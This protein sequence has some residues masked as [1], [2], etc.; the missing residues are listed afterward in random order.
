MANATG[1]YDLFLLKSGCFRAISRLVR[2]RRTGSVSVEFALVIPVLMLMVVGIADVGLVLAQYL[3]VSGALSA[4]GQY[5]LI[6]PDDTA[7]VEQIAKDYLSNN[8]AVSVMVETS[9][10]CS[11]GNSTTSCG[12]SCSAGEDLRQFV[13]IQISQAVELLLPYPGIPDAWDINMIS[14][15]RVQ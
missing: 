3:R 6:N 10:E 4:A 15:Y 13:R 14:Q 1:R 12:G 9:C 2:F 11:G 8:S 5:A 7:G